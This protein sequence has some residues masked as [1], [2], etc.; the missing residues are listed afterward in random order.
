MSRIKSLKVKITDTDFGEP[1]PLGAD[2]INIDMSDGGN[3]E[4]AIKAR[5]TQDFDSTG[6][7]NAE[8][9][10]ADRVKGHSIEELYSDFIS[11]TV[12]AA[13]AVPNGD[14]LY[15][16]DVTVKGLDPTKAILGIQMAYDTSISHEKALAAYQWDY[17]ET[18]TNKVS[19]YSTTQ[20]AN[21]FTIV[22]VVVQ[23]EE[24]EY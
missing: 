13:N 17:L 9:I 15:Y 7:G 18:G 6:Y 21:S 20:W 19:F 16:A 24:G 10:N 14:G 3:A 12:P 5:V 22:G 8:D 23:A 11:I 2:A 4:N 1:I